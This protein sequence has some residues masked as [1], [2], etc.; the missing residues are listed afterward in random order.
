MI[1]V[2]R[3][4]IRWSTLWIFQTI[5]MLCKE[6]IMRLFWFHF[7]NSHW[8]CGLCRANFKIHIL[9][10]PSYIPA[11]I[12]DEMKTTIFAL[13]V[14]YSFYF[15]FYICFFQPNDINV[16]LWCGWVPCRFGPIYMTWK[17]NHGRYH[18]ANKETE[19]WY[20]FKIIMR[21]WKIFKWKLIFRWIFK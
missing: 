18:F 15:M 8:F 10:L 5:L 19:N 1:F 20:E 12:D 16:Q 4:Q 7:Y 2:R 17:K 6:I 14:S 13:H 21:I 9:L 11:G 3:P